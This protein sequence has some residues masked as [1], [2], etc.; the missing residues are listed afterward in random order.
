M[1]ID[2]LPPTR[3]LPAERLD[4]LQAELEIFAAT[5][6]GATR[7]SPRAW[8]RR[9][10]FVIGGGIGLIVVV[11][12]G[13][14]LAVS[15]IKPAPVTNTAYAR[16]YSVATYD[17]GS[18]TFSGTTIA[19]PSSPTEAGRVEMAVEV[20]SALWQAGILQPG[21][22]TSIVH[23]GLSAYSV[24]ALVGC[25]LPDGAAAVFP[26]DAETCERL[27]LAAE[28]PPAAQAAQ[29]LSDPASDRPA[30]A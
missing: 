30:W 6:R 5:D 8:W 24:P 22:P 18:S 25:T 1:S 15:L 9:R 14:A 2:Y 7:W 16:C 17:A 28:L 10:G 19:Q 23:P 27:G 21:T 26:G 20:C 12:G 4:E 29:P 11:S 3:E 13:T